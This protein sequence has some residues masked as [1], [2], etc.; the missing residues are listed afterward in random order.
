MPNFASSAFSSGT[1]K[2]KCIRRANTIT[3]KYGD[4]DPNKT[5]SPISINT[6]PRYIGFLLL[7]KTPV[8]IKTEDSSNGLTIVVTSLKSLSATRFN[9]HPRAKGIIA[10]R[11]QG[12]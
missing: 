7:R 4:R 12:N 5:A 2:T 9:I 6:I 11:C 8:V 3:I 1:I 10:R